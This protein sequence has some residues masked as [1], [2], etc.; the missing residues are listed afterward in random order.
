VTPFARLLRFW[1]WGE[2]MRREQHLCPCAEV[3]ST[4]PLDPGSLHPRLLWSVATASRA[5]LLAVLVL[6]PA[7]APAAAGGPV[8][9]V[10]GRARRLHLEA[11]ET[12]R[13]T[14]SDITLAAFPSACL[15]GGRWCKGLEAP[16]RKAHH[17]QQEELSC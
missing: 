3:G 5:G 7:A 8:A 16:P 10:A 13:L 17:L 4:I 11:D 15:L 12:V 1:V 2:F 14:A 9:S 6:T